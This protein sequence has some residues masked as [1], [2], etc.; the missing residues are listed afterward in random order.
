MLTCQSLQCVNSQQ[1]SGCADLQYGL[2]K[3]GL[4]NTS[5]SAAHLVAQTAEYGMRQLHGA[6]HLLHAV[7]TVMSGEVSDEEVVACLSHG[8]LC[9][10]R[11][12]GASGSY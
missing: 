5:R 11:H 2:V 4:A 6:A 8:W 12:Q 7:G 3:R 9:R 1:P 10:D